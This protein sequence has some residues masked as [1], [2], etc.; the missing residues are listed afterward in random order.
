MTDGG[1]TDD[2][3][4][5]DSRGRDL[6]DSDGDRSNP[7]EN[8]DTTDDPGD[9]DPSERDD[10][11]SRENEEPSRP[12]KNGPEKTS[13][14]E[15]NGPGSGENDGTD[16]SPYHPGSGGVDGTDRTVAVDSHDA[17]PVD[18]QPVGPRP[19]E[20][21]ADDGPDAT[22]APLR[23]ALRTDHGAVIFLR[24]ALTSVLT[25]A[26]IAVLLFAISGIWPPLVAVESGSMEPHMH[27]GDLVFLMDENRFPP[28]GAVAGT[29]VVTHRKGQETGYWSF[30][31]YGNVVVY[32]PDGGKGTPIIHRARFYVEEGDDWVAMADDAYLGG[33]DSCA[34]TFTCPAPHD[35]FITKGDNND[36]FDQVG[37][38]STV[39]E[40]AWIKGR[41]KVRVPW[42]GYVRLKLASSATP[43]ATAVPST[44]GG[45]LAGIVARLEFA[46]A[47][48]VGIQFARTL[49]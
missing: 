3:S 7:A 2:E 42:L 22:E 45:V 4:S 25:V 9:S 41:A 14:P 28:D 26:L 40:P 37:G 38:Q 20:T 29:G 13:R 33:V 39:V 34:E 8:S 47:A 43:A 12:E 48:L 6:G 5:G 46:I 44:I 49:N 18:A 31:D 19:A 35:G 21:E 16:G 24:D 23:W 17:R 11:T 1:G 27:R 10:P 32:R 36:E 15:K 30:G